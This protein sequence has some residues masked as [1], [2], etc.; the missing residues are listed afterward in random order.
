MIEEKIQKKR[1]QLN[2]S[3]EKNRKYEDVYKLSVELDEL[4][5]EFYKDSQ[6]RKK[7]KNK[8]MVKGK[9]EINKILYIA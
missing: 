6:N 3:I 5:A 4:I 1:N 7:E 9:K 2:E 8:R